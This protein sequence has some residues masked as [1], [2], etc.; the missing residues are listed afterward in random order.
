METV[1]WRFETEQSVLAAF[2]AFN[3]QLFGKKGLHIHVCIH[4]HVHVYV[5]Q[6]SSPLHHLQSLACLLSL[7]AHAHTSIPGQKGNCENHVNR[8]VNAVLV[9]LEK[10]FFLL[11]NAF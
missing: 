11:S 8:T 1:K 5:G 4:V 9:N 2:C 6:C 10:F 3:R 7:F